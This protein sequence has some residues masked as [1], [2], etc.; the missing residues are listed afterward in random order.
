M[1][2][3]FWAFCYIF[4]Y[5]MSDKNM[6]WFFYQIS[7]LGRCLH[8][9]LLLLFILVLT[10]KKQIL[11]KQSLIFLMFIP[12]LISIF[13][14]LTGNFVASDIIM[15]NGAWNEVLISNGF[16]WIFYGTYFISYDV[17]SLYL[18]FDWSRKT[19]STMEKKQANIIFYSAVAVMIVALILN[20]ILPTIHSYI[21][22]ATGQI[23]GLGL[24]GAIWWA[25][26]HY[27]LMKISPSLAAQ[28]IMD[29]I[30]DLVI[31]IDSNGRIKEV[32]KLAET[33]LGFKEE[34]LL[35][36]EWSFIIKKPSNYDIILERVY[37]L[38]KMSPKDLNYS[39]THLL[40]S[41]IDLTYLNH[42]NHEI[43][44]KAFISLIKNKNEII[45][46]SVVGKDQRPVKNLENQIQNRLKA[47][48]KVK[49][50][51][52]ELESL[53]SIIASM[54]HA[55]TIPDLISNA[56][57]ATIQLLEFQR[58]GVF[59]IRDNNEAHLEML[60]GVDKELVTNYHVLPMNK[61]PYNQ[62]MKSKRSFITNRLDFS[63]LNIPL[64]IKIASMAVIPLQFQ[65]EVMGLLVV[66]NDKKR[67]FRDTE[68]EILETIGKEAGA[69]LKRINAE[70]K[71]RASL[72]E[73]EILL[74]EIHHRV[75]NNM[76][77]ISSLLNL[78]MAYVKDPEA[79]EVLRESQG[80]VASMAMVHEK[81]YQTENV[82]TIN[83][84]NYFL[85]LIE[86]I[87]LNYQYSHVNIK[88]KSSDI[89]LN[90]D[91]IMPLGLIVNEIITNSFKYA[92]IGRK[93]GEI[94][95]E[96]INKDDGKYQL[97]VSDNGVGMPEDIEIDGKKTLGLLL[98]KN[99]SSQLHG[100]Y[101]IERKKGTRF[102]IDFEEI[103]YK[104]RI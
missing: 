18:L 68:K 84:E 37:E 80:R 5:N 62:I 101:I 104:N 99:L 6:A 48:N 49:T 58:G 22:P 16:W 60:Y 63:L 21:F 59:I 7:S 43:P 102:I 76:Q 25:I 91:T 74:K 50:H 2:M 33:I 24:M 40:D 77:I 32:N 4:Y 45:G 95:L 100:E 71:I 69:T 86:T 94:K 38:R 19:K 34:E 66:L 98:V 52:K 30:N 26:T 12:P 103:K 46:Y 53:N 41:G 78:Q 82:G 87:M 89:T 81:L 64:H 67:P 42:M 13:Q 93:S 8:P 27:Q 73:K 83:L 97:L 15:V 65:G 96:V 90:I 11:K 35:D 51:L 85:D 1:A 47:E 44:V 9:A 54:N 57:H 61:F 56:L 10:K 55:T 23:L 31:L 28:N 92:F 20:T 72:E 3:A 14:T 36:K 70:D 88:V 29:Q 39:N 17:L 79:M 75:K